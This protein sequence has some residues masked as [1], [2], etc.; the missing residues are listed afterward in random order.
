MESGQE[1]G[2]RT[3]LFSFIQSHYSH[4]S[5]KSHFLHQVNSFAIFCVHLRPMFLMFPLI[6]PRNPKSEVR[7]LKLT[8]WGN[9]F[10]CQFG[11]THTIIR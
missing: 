2:L 7:N 3:Y 8:W 4:H 11:L 5:H 6:L 9:R 1:T 10:V